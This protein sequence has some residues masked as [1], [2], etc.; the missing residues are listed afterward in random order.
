MLKPGDRVRLV[1]DRSQDNRDYYGRLL[2]YVELRGRDLGRKQIRKGWAS[3]YVFDQRFRRLGSYRRAQRK[4]RS[5]H[6]GAWRECD[7]FDRAAL[8]SS[9]AVMTTEAKAMA[10]ELE[11]R[12]QGH[13]GTFSDGAS[14]TRTR[15]LLI[16]NRVARSDT[17][18]RLW[19]IKRA[20][21]RGAATLSVG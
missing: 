16:A 5:V 3:V 15:D 9:P 18:R 14:G 1:R 13:C 12:Q 8:G 2:R 4:A 6:R 20:P 21:A 17:I 10:A 7:G 11:R 19:P